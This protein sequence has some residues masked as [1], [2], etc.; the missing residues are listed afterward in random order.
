MSFAIIVRYLSVHI[1]YALE[2][3]CLKVVSVNF[4]MKKQGILLS[5]WGRDPKVQVVDQISWAGTF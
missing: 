5:P 2:A 4:L 3:Y 1:C